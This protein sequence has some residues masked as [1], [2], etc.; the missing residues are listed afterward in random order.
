MANGT[1]FSILNTFGIL[2]VY[3]LKEYALDDPSISFKTSWIGST[4]TSVTFLM[5]IFASMC[6]ERFGIRLTAFFG[7]ALGVVGLFSSAF[8]QQLELLY[9]TF[10][11]VLGVGGG[12]AYFTSLVILGHYFKKHMGIVNGVVSLGSSIYTVSLSIVLPIVL[13]S[14]SIKYT[15]IILGGLYCMLLL[16][17]LTWKPFFQ[18]KTDNPKLDL[19]KETD[20]VNKCSCSA[21]YYLNWKVFGNRTYLVWFLGFI[22]AFFGY[23]VPFVHLVKHTQ[24]TFPGSN[25]FILITCLQVTSGLGRIVFGK[26]ADLKCVNRIYMQ[27]CAFVLT[28]VIT[29]CIPFSEKFEG[30]IVI[31]LILGICDGIIVCLVGPIA[32]DIVGP[33]DASQAIGFLLGGFSIPFAV[34]PPIAG[35]LYDHLHTYEIAFVVAGVPPIVG[36]I[37]MCLIPRVVRLHPATTETYTFSSISILDVDHASQSTLVAPEHE[38]VPVC[39]IELPPSTDEENTTHF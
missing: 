11:L 15:F 28:G 25:A 13:E 6:S 16:C 1:N 23:F 36:A 31:C 10:G 37:I 17:T 19:S 12:F 33:I 39:S 22:V 14:L 9:L 27:Q 3:L 20:V 21:K 5:S 7:A 26:I 18:R 30:L 32:F 2:Y 24:D 34:G 4:C 35:L 29:A 38:I 8:I